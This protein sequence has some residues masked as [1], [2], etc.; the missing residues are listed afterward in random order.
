MSNQTFSPTNLDADLESS[1]ET[2]TNHLRDESNSEVPSAIRQ[3][4]DS[5]FSQNLE[6]NSPSNEPSDETE[7]ST[8]RLQQIRD[9]LARQLRDKNN[10]DIELEIQEL[11][12]SLDRRH[13][14]ESDHYADLTYD[15]RQPNYDVPQAPTMNSPM[16][17]SVTTVK[18]LLPPI[19][20]IP[21]K[22]SKESMGLIDFKSVMTLD[23]K[24]TGDI[25][26]KFYQQSHQ[27]EFTLL[28]QQCI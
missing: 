25:A 8:T 28:W 14:R 12:N 10:A 24:I 3:N 6:F 23:G 22:E 26:E 16:N 13:R 9:D 5:S 27:A 1:T 15:E 11:Q 2:T 19:P 7:D 21:I 18:P 4:N 17:S 20:P